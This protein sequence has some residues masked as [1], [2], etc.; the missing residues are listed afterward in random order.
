MAGQL[1][2][3]HEFL[4]KEDPTDA[5][6]WSDWME[7]FE[8][9]IRAL[10]ITKLV[11]DEEKDKYAL[12]YHY[13]GQQVR[14]ILKKLEN[15]GSANESYTAAKTA[16]NSH[17]K[18]KMNR[19]FLMHLLHQCKQGPSESMD[20]FY[21]RVR[22]TMA[23]L[24]LSNLTVNELIELI[25]L[26]QLVNN[27]TSNI[28]RKKALKD[29]LTLKAFL[30]HARAHERAEL[31]SQE[32]EKSESASAYAV[33]SSSKSNRN[34]S[35]SKQRYQVDQKVKK[36]FNCGGQYPHKDGKCPGKSKKTHECWFCGGI[37]P[38]QGKCPAANHICDKCNRRGHLEK[39]C[40]TKNIKQITSYSDDEYE[41]PYV[42][43][44]VQEK[45]RRQTQ[46]V[47][48]GQTVM[49]VIDTGA[50]V[51]VMSVETSEKLKL[52]INPEAKKRLY[53]YGRKLLPI[54]GS[55]TV[56]AT[57][58]ATD[59]TRN[60][61]FQVVECKAETLL[62]CNTSEDLGL[63]TFTQVDTVCPESTQNILEDFKDRFSGI[64]KMTDIQVKLHIDPEV[65][66]IQQKLRRIPFHLR[67]S[68]ENELERLEN[69]DIIE[70]ANGPTT[71][72]SPIVVVP[73]L[74]SQVPN[75]QVPCD[76]KSKVRICIDSRAINTA[77]KRERV[78]IPTLDDLKKDLNG[79]AIFSTIDLNKG[80]HQLELNEESRPI[81]TFITHQGLYRYKRL[82]FGINSAAE[83]FQQKIEDM[84][85]GIQGVKNISDD[86]II[87]ARNEIEHDKILKQ[88]LQRMQKW[89][90]TANPEKCKFKQ[91]SVTYFGHIFSK[92]GMR[93][94]PEK[95]A[96]IVN[97]DAPSSASEVRS[98]LGMAQYISHFVA[99]F[100]DIVAPLRRLTHQDAKFKW[101][102]T[103]ENAFKKL[104]QA[105][106]S[107]ETVEY[108]DVNLSTEVIVDAS[109]IGLGA[110]LTQR[111]HNNKVRIIE[112]ASRPLTDTE[113]R[114]SQTEREMLGVVWGCE[115]FNIY[116]YGS[117]FKVKT[118]HKPLL[119]IVKHTSKPTARLERLNLRLQPY[120]MTLIYKPGKDNEA[121]Y[122]S[123]HPGKKAMNHKSR[124]DIQINFVCVNALEEYT[125]DGLTMQK[126]KEATREDPILQ[127]VIEM[128][129]S[130]ANWQK[131][132]EF[133]P[134]KL[135]SEE[136]SVS[137][138]L[139]MR[140]DRIVIPKKLQS[141]VI[142][143]AHSSHQGIV[144][145]KSFLRETVWFP[146]L[147]RLVEQAVQE[148]LP[149][150][151]ATRT[152]RSVKAPL[153]MTKIPDHPWEEVSAD[154][155]GPL[156]TGEYLL[157]VVDDNSRF[158]EVEI[159][160]SL[161]TK[162]VIPK[163]DAMFARHGI[164][165]VVKTD[166]GPPFN[167]ELFTKWGASIGFTHRKITPLWP[168]A[169]GE[170][171]RMMGTLGKVIRISHLEKKNWKQQLYN[172]LRHYRATPHSTTGIS[173]AE[174]LYGRKIRTEIPTISSQKKT[175]R[176]EDIAK[177]DEEMKEKMK[178]IE[179]AKNNAVK[180]NLQVDDR[181][182]VKQK[183]SR[184]SETPYKPEPYQV[185]D[186]NG[187][188]ITARNNN[189]KI[190]RNVSYFKKVSENCG[191]MEPKREEMDS[192][193]TD[194]D[195]EPETKAMEAEVEV[196]K[197]PEL[198]QSQRIRKRPEY[199]KDYVEMISAK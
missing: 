39:V 194:D 148:C 170:A 171:E 104:K 105:I 197:T 28:L 114:Y 178:R 188:M 113:Q 182:L 8:A 10:Q 174:M 186:I 101:G 30:E 195:E 45:P 52:K 164:P 5:Q 107:S 73:K 81:T 49:C 74:N 94:T 177:K 78:V 193:V 133:W 183:V 17:F 20:T 152:Y 77:I 198:R 135:V 64:G 140:G 53:G 27:S 100:S 12:L 6:R 199:L 63:V 129:K 15:N 22:E 134:Y 172:F 62:S 142:E 61:E 102:E 47:M 46:V 48:N 71:W 153:E 25:T 119:G 44:S 112:Y 128:I 96:A 7:G 157:V 176:F 189:H 138:G 110:V 180:V 14:S 83:L 118:D 106:A 23:P 2:V 43:C 4:P 167:G 40:R 125:G 79:A 42:V 98:L 13:A 93:P 38:H 21:M 185:T 163:F 191:K 147:D 41:V 166:N 65:K 122:L 90:I 159:I 51:N 184:K 155:Y 80:Y 97:A 175:V 162:T 34:R 149:C 126:L 85:Q 117:E 9:M 59:Q 121:D 145:T 11:E 84:L 88:V 141:K 181:V 72:I 54:L 192:D 50:E 144:K 154:F 136:L 124:I 57:S 116:L 165:K 120:K 123:R 36:C 26:S 1:P 66:P 99:N 127:S 156:S 108:F 158:P 55:V 89:N 75:N 29:G 76:P 86:I 58:Q 173:P 146:G 137:D 82:C 60:L 196:N 92:D 67:S 91:E 33:G 151:A 3:Y 18:P 95:I 190:T 115:H 132:Q 161:S 70:K 130:K 103:E 111:D 16:L 37:Y 139:V 131:S 24:E 160:S 87:F 179:D 143:I 169:N 68:L 109:P 31:Q 69:L 150:Q 56:E 32:I 35:K 187:T 19:V 168:Q